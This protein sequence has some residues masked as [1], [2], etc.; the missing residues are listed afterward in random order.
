MSNE[1]K[2]VFEDKVSCSQ[3]RAIANLIEETYFNDVWLN[4]EHGSL[5]VSY[6]RFTEDYYKRVY[7]EEEV[8][9]EDKQGAVVATIKIAETNA[10]DLCNRK[11]KFD[12]G[13]G[14]FLNTIKK[15]P[16]DEEI[17]V[18]VITEN[19]L[20]LKFKGIVCVCKVRIVEYDDD[21]PVAVSELSEVRELVSEIEFS[22]V[23]IHHLIAQL[24]DADAIDTRPQRGILWFD[25]KNKNIMSTNALKMWYEK[26]HY[27]GELKESYC[28]YNNNYRQIGAFIEAQMQLV[29]K[30]KVKIFNKRIV[31]MCYSE[32]EFLGVVVLYQK[33][34]PK[35][36]PKYLDVAKECCKNTNIS[37][38]VDLSDFITMLKLA[39]PDFVVFFKE[40][41]YISSCIGQLVCCKIT[42]SN[43]VFEEP[44]IV[45]FI[46]SDIRFFEKLGSRYEKEGR[47]SLKFFL[48][49]DNNCGATACKIEIVHKNTGDVHFSLYLMSQEIDKKRRE[50]ILALVV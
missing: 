4:I 20:K 3:L 12:G 43:K 38:S 33:K 21:K 7:E 35:D 17:V 28:F 32:K 10:S 15:L 44:F 13:Y 1:E 6:D 22:N 27:D 48:R 42:H 8:D 14:I 24:R 50:K 26:L 5:Y 37:V 25:A 47:F 39:I 31:F 36:L 40:K 41:M 45:S 16:Q 46:K 49:E 19:F 34:T 2:V 18:I 29:E 30:L 23:Q 11:V 9:E